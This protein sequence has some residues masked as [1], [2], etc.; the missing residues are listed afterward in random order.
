MIHNQSVA[1]ENAAWKASLRQE[2]ASLELMGGLRRLSLSD[3]DLGDA[4]DQLAL[5]LNQDNCMKA[6]D[7]QFWYK[8]ILLVI[9]LSFIGFV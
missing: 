4:I 3:N 1:R 6:L 7:L 2:S 8:D 5:A 9:K